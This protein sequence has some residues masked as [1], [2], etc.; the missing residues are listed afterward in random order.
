MLFIMYPFI[1]QRRCC[2]VQMLRSADVAQRDVAQRDVAQ[3]DVAQRDVAQ[4]DVAQ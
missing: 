4:R 2:A 1:A 3:R